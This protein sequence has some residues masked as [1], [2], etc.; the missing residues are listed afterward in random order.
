MFTA[1][2]TMVM[3]V[4]TGLMFPAI[5]VSKQDNEFAGRVISASGT[6]IVGGEAANPGHPVVGATVYL[7]PTTAMDV[8]TRM[9]ASAIYAEP[10]PAEAY[11]EPL[12]DTIRL[13]GMDF[14][15]STTDSEGRFSIANVPD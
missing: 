2:I 3:M 11:D 1:I 7:V 9:T 5:A 15:Q 6:L 10:Y 14:P 8:T 12:E 4:T 13:K